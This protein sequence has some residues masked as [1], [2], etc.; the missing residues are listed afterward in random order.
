MKAFKCDSLILPLIGIGFC[1]LL[2]WLIAGK[3]TTTHTKDDWGD[4]VTITKRAGLSAD[5]PTPG[6]TWKASS[7]YVLK[8]FE[9]RGEL[10]QGILRF[11]WLSLT[12][13][14]QGYAIALLVGTPL[15]FC[16]G[17]SRTFAK[18]FDPIF[19]VLRPVSPLAW[20]PL[21]MVLFLSAKL[22]LGGLS[23][24]ASELA[25]IFTIA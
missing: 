8:P 1:L 21:G 17:L 22:Q 16:L 20:L 5:L 9:K 23:Y 6:E 11:T 19:Q 7:Q 10:D 15:G 18:M 4:P 25:A 12:L 14:A 2:W 24:T 3:A 13:V